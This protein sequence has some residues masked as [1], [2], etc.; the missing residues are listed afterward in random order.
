MNLF[1]NELM[2]I[3]ENI[4]ECFYSRGGTSQILL[5]NI[6]VPKLDSKFH[7]QRKKLFLLKRKR[8]AF[9]L[10][11]SVSVILL[12]SWSIEEQLFWIYKKAYSRKSESIW[13]VWHIARVSVLY[14]LWISGKFSFEILNAAETG[15][16]SG[17]FSKGK[18]IFY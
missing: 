17:R 13:Q 1:L 2:R 11:L 10:K 8:L 14:Q 18:A 4:W 16:I 9:F 12:L 6:F 15:N 7:T 3:F 5:R